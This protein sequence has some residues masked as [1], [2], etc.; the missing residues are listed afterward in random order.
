MPKLLYFSPVNHT[1][2][3]CR[4]IGRGLAAS[5]QSVAE[6]DLTEPGGEAASFGP[7]DVVIIG[8]PVYGGRVPAL[9]L[10][11][12]RKFRGGGARAVLV[13]SYGN[14]AFED[15]LLELYDSA[16]ECGF[17][18]IAAA[19][20][21]AEHTIAP[22]IAAGRPDREDIASIE[23]FAGAVKGVLTNNRAGEASEL[24]IPGN[25]PYREYSPKPLPQTVNDNCIECG[26]CAAR[27]PSGAI[28]AADIRIV[29]QDKCICCMACINV[30]P[31]DARQPQPAFIA[32]VTAMLDKAGASK[33]KKNEYFLP[34]A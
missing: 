26:Q 11:R 5:A 25:R 10:E 18:P 8:I 13:A 21:I 16:R 7:D 23:E 14:R 4:I 22:T 29:D 30:C 27:C 3:I 1:R 24:A 28:D 19:A 15:A 6:Y 31:T 32:A 17:K 12:L 33:P 9:A 2:E 20:C 34:Q